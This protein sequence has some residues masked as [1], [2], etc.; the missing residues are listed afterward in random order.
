MNNQELFEKLEILKLKKEE[1]FQG[2]ELIPSLV[3]G[4]LW[5]GNYAQTSNG[6]SIF[7]PACFY[8]HDE[9]EFG[10]ISLYGG[11]GKDFMRG[12]RSLISERVGF[13]RRVKLYRLFHLLNHWHHFGGAYKRHSLSLLDQLI[14]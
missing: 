9:F 12:Y 11:L 1:L 13:E 7:D 8:A 4:D 5:S 10:M 3:H 2:A 14:N 6:P